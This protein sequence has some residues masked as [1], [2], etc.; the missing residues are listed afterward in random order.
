MEIL[1][2][3]TGVA[4]GGGVGGTAFVLEQTVEGSPAL[5]ALPTDRATGAANVPGRAC[6]ADL[7]GDGKAA[8]VEPEE[9]ATLFATLLAGSSLVVPVYVRRQGCPIADGIGRRSKG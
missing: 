9:N 5:L 1:L 3:A 8:G 7:P 4:A 2:V 6:R